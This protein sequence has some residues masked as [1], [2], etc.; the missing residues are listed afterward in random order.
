MTASPSTK[1]LLAMRSGG[2]C[3]MPACGRHLTYEASVGADTY[4]AEAAH[5]RGEKPLAPRYDSSMSDAERNSIENLIYFCT[6]HHTVIDKVPADWPVD[7]LV[8]IKSKHESKV[9]EV[10]IDAFADVNFPELLSAVAWV[11]TSSDFEARN[12]FEIISPDEKIKKNGLSNFSKTIIISGL[13]SQATVA[14]FVE[15]EAQTDSNFP[16]KLKAGFLAEYY[17]LIHKGHTGDEL[18]ELMCAFA[19]RGLKKQGEQTAGLAVLVYLFEICDI[20]EK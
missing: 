12:S 6:D 5:I 15:A 20:F 2:V 18:F 17:S 8:E 3:A 11:T 9:R 1:I 10:M 19:T 14:G 13:V 4:V 7:R 16:D